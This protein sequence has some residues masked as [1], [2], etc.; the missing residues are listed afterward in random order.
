[1]KTFHKLNVSSQ[2]LTDFTSVT[3]GV[4][5]CQSPIGYYSPR[6][7]ETITDMNEKLKKKLITTSK[8]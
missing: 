3:P 1:M 5:S 7:E 8:Y 2:D 4:I 6:E